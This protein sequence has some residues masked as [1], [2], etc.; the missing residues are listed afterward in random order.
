[1]PLAATA[2]AGCLAGSRVRGSCWL[3]SCQTANSS[4][5]DARVEEKR[6]AHVEQVPA[7]AVEEGRTVAACKVEHPA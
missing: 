6:N 2:G 1:M 4:A 5:P 3:T 7:D